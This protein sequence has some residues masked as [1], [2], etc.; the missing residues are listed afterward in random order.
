M[1]D[2]QGQKLIEYLLVRLTIVFGVISFLVGIIA[3]DFMLMVYIN[4]AGLAVT[5]LVVL[6]DWPWY[7]RNAPT[8]LPPKIPPI[9]QGY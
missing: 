8:W 6:P 7:R 1:P 4:G 9:T 2:F 5:S 3:Q